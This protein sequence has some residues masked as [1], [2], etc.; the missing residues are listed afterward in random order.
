LTGYIDSTLVYQGIRGKIPIT[1]LVEVWQ[2]T[3]DIPF[4]DLTFVLDIEPN[5]TAERVNKRR[6]ETG[7][8]PN[9]WD[10]S[11]LEFHQVIRNGYLQMQSYFS[12]RVRIINADKNPEEVFEEVLGIIIKKRRS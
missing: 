3:I 8:E 10:N 7:E 4:P 12:E 11:K 9:N 1:K 2:N 6:Q 5:K